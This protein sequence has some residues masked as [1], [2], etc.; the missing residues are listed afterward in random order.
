MMTLRRMRV[1]E[2]DGVVK[3]GLRLYSRMTEVWFSRICHA[4]ARRRGECAARLEGS[5]WS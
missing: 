2:V 3:I 5:R 4:G 1:V